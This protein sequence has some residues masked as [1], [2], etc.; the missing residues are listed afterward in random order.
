[1][2]L[3]ALIKRLSA[4]LNTF[5]QSGDSKVDKR[6]FF[7]PS[8]LKRQKV[9]IGRKSNAVKTLIFWQNDHSQS[10]GTF[11]YRKI[12]TD[13]A[14]TKARFLIR[15]K[16]WCR[17]KRRVCALYIKGSRGEGGWWGGELERERKEK[18][19]TYCH[20]SSK[21]CLEKEVCLNSWQPCI[22]WLE[23][24]NS[25][26]VFHVIPSGAS[27]AG[28]YGDVRATQRW[29]H[30]MPTSAGD[31]QG[32]IFLLCSISMWLGS[33]WQPLSFHLG[34]CI[35]AREDLTSFGCELGSLTLRESRIW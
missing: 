5:W 30:L 4:N 34:P 26:G 1:M 7:F 13:F 33:S 9:Y 31:K 6:G 2:K 22:P 14:G 15:A 27:S 25:P 24:G 3:W 10:E 35:F 19:T 16:I 8:K 18:E 20:P 17:D 12:A 11:F 23:R 28:S 21:K 32:R 29:S